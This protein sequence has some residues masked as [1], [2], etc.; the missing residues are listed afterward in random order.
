MPLLLYAVTIALATALVWHASGWLETSSVRLASHYRLPPVVQ[1]GVIAAVGSSF[2]ELSSTVLSTLVHGEFELGV[3]VIV[4]S[5]IFNILVIPGVSGLVG[6][7]LEPDWK[8]VYKDAQFYITSVAVLLLT[9]SLA[10]IY[11][12]VDGAALTGELTQAMALIPIAVYGLY[13]F[14]MQQDAA[15]HRLEHNA[16]PASGLRPQ[17]EWL[18]LA[19]SL[20]LILVGVEALVRA[21]IGLGDAFDTPSFLWGLTVLA[22]ATS[23]PDLFVSVR[24]ARKSEGTVSLANVLGSN[25]FDLLVAVPIGVLIAGS[26]T[27]DYAAAAP[28]M[29]ALTLATIVLFAMLRT[30]MTLTR[31]ECWLLL[32]LYLVF[33]LWIGLETAGVSSALH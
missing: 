26:T 9:F 17:R 7:Q 30:G 33:V 24:A 22:A 15:D 28:M 23:I 2:P 14:L 27:I 12:P 4:G 19:L 11:R 8:L 21:V 20:V 3:G 10:V 16:P 18:R 31:S 25:I 32:A 13:L 29:A 5:A 1:G 6:G